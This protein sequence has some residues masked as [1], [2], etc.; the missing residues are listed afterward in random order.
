MMSRIKPR[1]MNDKGALEGLPLYLIILVVIAG[2][3]TAI[4]VGWMM[5]AQSQE[6][7][8]IEVDYSGASITADSNNKVTVKAYDQDGN[9]LK[10]ATVKLQGCNVNEIGETDENGECEFTVRPSL[11]ENDNFGN[12][13][14][15]VEYTGDVPTQKP[16]SIPVKT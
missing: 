15:T 11:P 4:I 12:I 16:G 8:S 7:N 13:D 9:P 14:V 2:V 10:G 5:S 6:L 3:A 1:K